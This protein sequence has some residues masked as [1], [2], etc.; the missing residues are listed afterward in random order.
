L[1]AL[2]RQP[3]GLVS[4]AGER[5]CERLSRAANLVEVGLVCG[6]ALCGVWGASALV[7]DA[8]RPVGVAVAAACAAW[9]LWGSPALHHDTRAARGLPDSLSL[10]SQWHELDA[11]GHR[12]MLATTAVFAVVIASVLNAGWRHLLVRVGFRRYLAPAYAWLAFT[13]EGWTVGLLLTAG[14][15]MLGGLRLVRWQTWL[16]TLRATAWPALVVCAAIVLLGAATADTEDPW[17][18]TSHAFQR[19]LRYLFWGFLQQAL[20]LGWLN[21]RLRRAIPPERG[22][23]ALVATL[24]GGVFA[25]AHAPNLSLAAVAGVGDVWLAWLFQRDRTRNLVA[26]GLVHAI[27]AVMYAAFVPGT[28][29]VGPR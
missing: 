13:S 5:E 16:A 29:E 4:A 15:L 11:A 2:T 19:S 9:A 14:L 22:S 25:L 21:T 7:G 1:Q 28:M 10:R 27:L 23:R 20:V 12:L 8:G 18:R 17:P 26:A 3:Q 24:C 6:L